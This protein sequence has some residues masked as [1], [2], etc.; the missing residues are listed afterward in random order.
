MADQS[1]RKFLTLC[2]IVILL[3]IAFVGVE[4]SHLGD[5]RIYLEA[6]S[7]LDGQQDIYQYYYGKDSLLLYMGSP[8]LAYMLKP[9]S[10]LPP[11]FATSLWKMLNIL[12]LFRIWRLIELQLS[13]PSNE[14]SKLH[15]NWMLLSIFTLAFPIYRNFHLSQFTFLLL[16][17][18]LEGVYQIRSRKKPFLGSLL[19]SFG[20]VVKLLP[21]VALPYLLF[22]G[23]WRQ[24]LLVVILAM[25]F[26][27][28][29]VLSYGWEYTNMLNWSWIETISPTNEENIFDVTGPHTHGIAALISTLLIEGIGNLYSLDYKRNILDL[30]P[31]LVVLVIMIA[32]ITIIW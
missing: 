32:K 29:P 27:M 13:N 22:R 1:R 24:S 31:D 20:I 28:A 23:Y 11:H 16:F 6:S 25:A 12:L 30:R 9:L 14:Q 4:Y 2:G 5:L 21:I 15:L 18:I 3:L 10:L 7:A 17:L 19:L 26:Y 8:V